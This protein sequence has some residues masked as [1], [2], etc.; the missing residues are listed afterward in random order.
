MLWGSPCPRLELSPLNSLLGAGRAL[1]FVSCYWLPYLCPDLCKQSL[2]QA[3]PITPSQRATHFLQEPSLRLLR[4][5]GVYR[6]ET[7]LDSL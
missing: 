7:L 5:Q 4:L 3:P 1:T 2:N 6:A